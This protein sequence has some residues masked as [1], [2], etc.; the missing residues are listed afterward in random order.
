MD[1]QKGFFTY[2]RK[3][4]GRADNILPNAEGAGT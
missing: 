2:V 1:F 3:D 4:A